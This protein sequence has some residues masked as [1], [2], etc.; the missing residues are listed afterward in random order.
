MLA[1][2]ASFCLSQSLSRAPRAEGSNLGSTGERSRSNEG[3]R[4]STAAKA[5]SSGCRALTLER[6][7]N[8]WRRQR[9]RKLRK[10]V[11]I[12]RTDMVK[13]VLQ[14]VDPREH[15]ALRQKPME[16]CVCLQVGQIML[17]NIDAARRCSSLSHPA[18]HLASNHERI[19]HCCTGC[20]SAPSSGPSASK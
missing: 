1:Q 14:N 2:N 3:E 13:S 16:A 4:C 5:L 11:L 20:P 10:I 17:T 15:C 6:I 8:I 12:H 18:K 9:C 7:E 19:A